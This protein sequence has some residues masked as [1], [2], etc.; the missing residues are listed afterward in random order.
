[1]SLI[2]SGNNGAP[3]AG[4]DLSSVLDGVQTRTNNL[5]VSANALASAMTK[6]FTQASSGGKQFDDVLKSLALRLS[7]LAVTQAFKP[8]AK[9]L[10]GGLGDLLG[11]LFG[12]GSGG[13]NL[14]AQM[15]AIKPFAAGGV[16]GTPTYFPLSSGG[17]G[18]AGEAGPEAIVPLARGADGSL[19]IAMN[20]GGEG[21]NITVQ[22]ATPDPGSFRRSEAYITGQ[23]ARAVARGQRSL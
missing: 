17:L 14:F 7:S 16:I 8:F 5:G 6:A 11:S 21:A 22:I 9:G 23:I 18:L 1:M 2:D 13:G 3:S 20:G 15:G 4:N 12:G 19:G 10:T